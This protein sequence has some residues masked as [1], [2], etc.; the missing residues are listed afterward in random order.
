[1][2]LAP[3]TH[4]YTLALILAV[5]ALAFVACNGDSPDSTPSPTATRSPAAT[6]AP[7]STA[8]PSATVAASTPSPPPPSPTPGVVTPATIISRG[9][10]SRRQ[11]ALTFDAGSDAGYTASILATLG[12]AGIRASFGVTGLWAEENKDL[13]LAIAA[14]GHEFI[15]H[16]YDH[17]SF[18]GFSTGTAPLTPAERAS[19]LSRTETT[20]FR[21]TGRSTRPYF[22]PPFGDL[23]STVQHDVAANGYNTIVMW[24]VD[25]FGWRR[26]SEEEIVTRSLSLA[27]PGAIYIMHVG[28]ES[29]DGP[30]LPRVI[31][32]LRAQG[33]TF[34]TITELLSP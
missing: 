33:Y 12:A 23:D 34:V 13:L 30:A 18:T 8:A 28:S 17:T 11:V 16:T 2:I 15:N 22:R 19:E 10:P 32:G 6:A 26:V 14:G 5:A 25:T 4:R 3:P 21:I 29:N 24:T 31:D 7:S 9:D 20:V 1:M 27:A